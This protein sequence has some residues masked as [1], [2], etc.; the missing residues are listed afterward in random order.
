[1]LIQILEIQNEIHTVKF[2][3][4]SFWYMSGLHEMNFHMPTAY[5]HFKGV[6]HIPEVLDWFTSSHAFSYSS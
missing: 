3:L 4:G 1:M 5:Y 2:A 6:F